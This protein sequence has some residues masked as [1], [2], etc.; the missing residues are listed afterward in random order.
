MRDRFFKRQFDRWWSG[1]DGVTEANFDEDCEVEV[2]QS[3]SEYRDMFEDFLGF[4][5][6]ISEDTPKDRKILVYCPAQEGL[7]EL[8]CFCQW[9][10][11]AGFCVDEIRNPT[12]WAE[13][14]HGLGHLL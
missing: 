12:H 3:K 2:W 13:I 4:L 9:H 7:P 14:P 10:P 8:V 1:R 6:P 11:D 5:A